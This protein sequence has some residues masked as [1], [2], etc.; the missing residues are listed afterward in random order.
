MFVF[1]K[2]VTSLLSA[3]LLLITIRLPR[4]STFVPYTTLFRSGASATAVMLMSNDC[5]GEVSCPPL[6][7]PP[8]SCAVSVIVAEPIALAAGGYV[9]TDEDLIAACTENRTE[10][11]LPVMVK[12][13]VGPL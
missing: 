8:L 10:L 6:P 5:G 3:T 11:V 13:T 1:L 7:V 12:G 4:V 2:C 9:V